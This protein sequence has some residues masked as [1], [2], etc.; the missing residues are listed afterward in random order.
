MY[1]SLQVKAG[2]YAAKHVAALFKVVVDVER[3]AAKTLSDALEHE[4]GKGRK[5][6]MQRDRMK[7]AQVGDWHGAFL[8]LCTR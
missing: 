7:S 4:E 3:A 2:I 1:H 6:K 5:E 8:L